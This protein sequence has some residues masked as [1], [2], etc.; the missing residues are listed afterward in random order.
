MKA[1]RRVAAV[2]ALVL[3]TLTAAAALASAPTHAPVAPQPPVGLEVEEYVALGDSYTAGPLISQLVPALGCFRS[4]QNYPALLAAALGVGTLT[5]VSCS[6]AG[7]ADLTGSQNTGFAMVPP[8]LAGLSRGTDLVTLGVGGNDFDV[9]ARLADV[10]P[11][12]RAEDPDGAPCRDHFRSGDRDTLLAAVART[13]DRVASVL[14]RVERRAPHATVLV[15][16]YPQIAPRDQTCPAVLPFAAGDYRYADR[17]ER[18]LN[19]AL[20]H[21]AASRGAQ[22]VDTYR[23]SR[24]HHACA[25]T[26]AWVNGQH[27]RPGRAQSYHP[28]RA[29]MR[30]VA[31]LVVR[32]L[33]R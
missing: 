24:G 23:A 29:Y 3:V 8:Q 18:G 19:A 6:G 30:A 12:L 33:A 9:F 25:G 21:A 2:A 5:D 10:C 20:R 15:I 17:V 7:T 14:H 1:V 22:Y 31:D 11:R 16:G 28:F 26:Q 27:T 13:G 4:T 32:R